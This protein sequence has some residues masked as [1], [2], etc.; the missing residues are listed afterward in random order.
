MKNELHLHSDVTN[1]SKMTV[2]LQ[3]VKTI[4]FKLYKFLCSA[5]LMKPAAA[6]APHFL[7]LDI[8]S[9]ILAE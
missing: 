1:S 3:F 9:Q 7:F 5:F 2:F 8:F 4:I 6:A